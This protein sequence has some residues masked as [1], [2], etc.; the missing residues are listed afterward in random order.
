MNQLCDF[1]LI[2]PLFCDMVHFTS[3]MCGFFQ[4]V[5]LHFGKLKDDLGCH[6]T[7]SRYPKPLTQRLAVIQTLYF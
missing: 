7:P 4:R 2:L 5:F 6:G 3:S 1:H